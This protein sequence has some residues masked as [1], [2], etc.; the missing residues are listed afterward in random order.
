M[1]RV[2]REEIPVRRVGRNKCSNWMGSVYAFSSVRL[3]EGMKT[4][5]RKRQQ[6]A[7]NLKVGTEALLGE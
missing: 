1:R 2:G 7:S 5:T 6:T 3:S 4:D